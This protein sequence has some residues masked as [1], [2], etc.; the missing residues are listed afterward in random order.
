MW[1]AFYALGHFG[2]FLLSTAFL[3]VF[4]FTMTGWWM[5]KRSVVEV[6]DRGVILK[7]FAARWE[8]ITATE[9]D[10][11]GSLI[12][13]KNDSDTASIPR[14]IQSLEALEAHIREKCCSHWN[15]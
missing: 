9:R 1:I 14:T 6:F 4:A 13:I 10:Q 11:Y 7:K 2:Y 3:I 15:R 8:E 5:Q 12:L